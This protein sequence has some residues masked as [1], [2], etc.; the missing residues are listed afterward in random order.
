MLDL[1]AGCI[2]VD[3]EVVA[4]AQANAA[5]IGGAI[6]NASLQIVVSMKVTLGHA[7]PL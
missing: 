2:T 5:D 6:I 7:V 1:D 3:A 4:L